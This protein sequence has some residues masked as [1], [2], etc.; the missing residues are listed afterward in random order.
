MEYVDEIACYEFAIQIGV[1]NPGA[2]Q[3]CNPKLQVIQVHDVVACQVEAFGVL[4]FGNRRAELVNIFNIKLTISIEV[5]NQAART[6]LDDQIVEETFET[7]RI[8]L[9]PKISVRFVTNK[10][11][12][13]R[14]IPRKCFTDALN[15]NQEFTKSLVLTINHL[16]EFTGIGIVASDIRVNFIVVINSFRTHITDKPKI[17]NQFTLWCQKDIQGT[18]LRSSLFVFGPQIFAIKIAFFTL[19]RTISGEKRTCRTTDR[20]K[21][22]GQLPARVAS[23]W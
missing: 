9:E 23:K 19:L 10:Y 8:E 12:I 17:G 3:V 1:P 13:T 15:F 11:A 21:L 2:L 18:C 20:L 16:T 14:G 22:E 4:T 6:R 5:P 7:I